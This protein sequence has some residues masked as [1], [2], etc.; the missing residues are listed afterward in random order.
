MNSQT[1]SEKNFTSSLITALSLLDDAPTREDVEE[2]ARQL[3][4]VFGYTGP[5]DAAIEEALIAIDT[6]M[7]AGTSLIDKEAEHDEEWVY[8]REIAWTYSEG[9][10]K[11]LKSEQ[12]YPAADFCN[13]EH[14][15][16]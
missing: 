10:E 4:Q 14:R 5:L 12:W 16:L 6:R 2:K 11:Y 8:K 3:S 15:I 9:Y 13:C 7:G 1:D